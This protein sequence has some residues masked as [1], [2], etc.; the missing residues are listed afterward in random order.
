MTSLCHVQHGGPTQE[1][2]PGKLIRSSR[3]MNIPVAIH[4]SV[5]M[6]AVE[7]GGWWVY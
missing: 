2:V 5:L 1:L 6:Q 7:P 3:S 4:T